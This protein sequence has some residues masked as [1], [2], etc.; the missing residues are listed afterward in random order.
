MVAE[1]TIDVAAK[2]ITTT[3][4][5]NAK[6]T[7]TATLNCGERILESLTALWAPGH[8]G[9]VGFRMEYGG[10]AM[11]P[12]NQA[13]AFL[14]GDNERITYD[15]SL[16]VSGLVTFKLSNTDTYRHSIIF[17]AKLT[18]LPTIGAPGIVLLDDAAI[19]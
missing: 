10:V 16:H 13:T 14:V 5:C 11:L 6:S 17:T 3:V 18:E 8:V 4:T 7:A 2:Y 15:L 9:L 19:A 12:W 1:R